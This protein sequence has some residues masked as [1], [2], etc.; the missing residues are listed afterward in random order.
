MSPERLDP[1]G[2]CFEDC[3]ATKESDCYALGIVI[4]E[5]L[6]GRVPF[7]WF[8]DLAVVMKVIGSGPPKRPGGAGAVRFT[9]DLWGMLQQCLSPQPKVRP[10]AEAILE[11]L[12]WD[13]MAWQPLPPDTDDDFQADSDDG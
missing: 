13:S 9:D 8:T 12:E 3:R 10:T 7:P 6:T 5:V 2:F 11:H 4:L 1:D